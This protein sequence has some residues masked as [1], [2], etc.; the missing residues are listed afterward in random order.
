MFAHVPKAHIISDSVII[1]EANIILP[2]RANIIL[3]IA[4]AGNYQYL[5]IFSNG[6]SKNVTPSF[7]V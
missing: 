3:I 1:R 7:S 2:A 5:P 4:L 6:M